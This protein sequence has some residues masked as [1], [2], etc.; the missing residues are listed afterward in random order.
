MCNLNEI[1]VNVMHDN[2]Y[3]YCLVGGNAKFTSPDRMYLFFCN[4]TNHCIDSLPLKYLAEF[5]FFVFYKM[6]FL[7]HLTTSMLKR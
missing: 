5:H 4:K 3:V 6:S 7:H 1:K 2:Q